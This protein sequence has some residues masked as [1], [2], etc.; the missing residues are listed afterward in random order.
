M[1][2]VLSTQNT[3]LR[4]TRREIFQLQC[5]DPQSMGAFEPQWI[6]SSYQVIYLWRWWHTRVR[7][8]LMMRDVFTSYH[9]KEWFLKNK[10]G[11][12]GGG[13]AVNSFF[14]FL[15]LNLLGFILFSKYICLKVLWGSF[16]WEEQEEKRGVWREGICCLFPHDFYVFEQ[17]WS[18][19]VI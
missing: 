17:F 6:S 3:R 13:L 4:K 11:D 14:F 2:I 10:G 16:K 19:Q 15:L 5:W 7:D 12:V 1:I 9:L 8:D 18:C